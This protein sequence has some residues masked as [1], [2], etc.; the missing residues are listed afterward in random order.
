MTTLQ[1]HVAEIDRM[2][3]GIDSL[4]VQ[5]DRLTTSTGALESRSKT[6][7]ELHGRLSDLESRVVTA[8]RAQ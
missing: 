2:R 5:V 3:P 1:G 8:P 7:D 4:R 6:V